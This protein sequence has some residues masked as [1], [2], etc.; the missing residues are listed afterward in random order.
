MRVWVASTSPA[1]LVM[2]LGGALVALGIYYLYFRVEGLDDS[3]RPQT[4]IFAVFTL[5]A[6]LTIRFNYMAEEQERIADD[7]P[8]PWTP[9]RG[10]EPEK[11]PGVNQKRRKGD[12]PPEKVA[13]VAVRASGPHGDL[14]THVALPPGANRGDWIR[15]SDLLTPSQAR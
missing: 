14:T 4:R 10:N 11:T 13:E 5:L 6:L 8:Q 3:L 7:E 15:T 1:Y 9:G 2:L 12:E